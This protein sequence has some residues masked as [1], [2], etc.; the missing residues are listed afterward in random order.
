[1]EEMALHVVLLH[2]RHSRGNRD[3]NKRQAPEIG[4]P[5]PPFS[6]T[7]WPSHPSRYRVGFAACIPTD[8]AVAL[9]HCAMRIRMESRQLSNVGWHL[10]FPPFEVLNTD[11][12]H[13]LALEPST[14]T[15]PRG[16][17]DA[18][19]IPGD[20]SH[21]GARNILSVNTPTISPRDAAGFDVVTND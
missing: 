10:R 14:E 5:I 3:S 16:G 7:I 1:M 2:R 8:T 11:T 6:I 9:F 18:I 15:I 17:T 20:K 4:V 13:L 19:N 21:N 12:V